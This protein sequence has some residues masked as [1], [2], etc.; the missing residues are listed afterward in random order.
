MSEL[1]YTPPEDIIFNE[2][3][4][5]AIGL[6]SGM[7][8]EPSYSAEKIGRIRDIKNVGDNLMYIVGMFDINNQ[9]LLAN[10]LSEEAKLAIRERM[11]DG[12]S[13]P[14]YIVF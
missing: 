8:D 4:E 13:P 6:W 9:R 14:E 1:Y 12:G 2:V 11:V 3:K 10:K 5:Q 7:G